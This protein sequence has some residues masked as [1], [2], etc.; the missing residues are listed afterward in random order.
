M[1]SQIN[2][3]DAAAII[4]NFNNIKDPKFKLVD[5][6]RPSNFYKTDLMTITECDS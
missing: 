3:K 5:L 2:R 6:I 4:K 1:N